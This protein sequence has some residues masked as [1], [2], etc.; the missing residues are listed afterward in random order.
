MT[1]GGERWVCRSVGAL[2][3][4]NVLL[5]VGRDV[6]LQLTAAPD[7]GHTKLSALEAIDEPVG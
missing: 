1:A 2:P 4:H 3:S 6:D 7:V 5:T